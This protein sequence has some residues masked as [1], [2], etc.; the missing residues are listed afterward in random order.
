VEESPVRRFTIVPAPV[1]GERAVIS[2]NG[3]H[4]AYVGEGSKLWIR[5]LDREQPRV[6]EGT[7]GAQYPFWSPDSE[8]LGFAMAGQMKRVPV[9]GG[10]PVT[11]CPLPSAAGFAGAAWNPDG[12]SIFFSSGS[13]A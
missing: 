3:R 1:P 8:L 5:D 9:T 6:L 7:D 4:I 10:A 2:P 11:V 12:D 13:Q